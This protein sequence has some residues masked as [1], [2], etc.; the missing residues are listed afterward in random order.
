MK[1]RSKT[2][3]FVITLVFLFLILFVGCN[4]EL[5]EE[6]TT[7]ISTTLIDVTNKETTPPTISISKP[8]AMDVNLGDTIEYIVSF[9]GEN[10]VFINLVESHI[11][12]NGFSAEVSVTGEALTRTIL[13]QNIQ[14]AA[15]GPKYITIPTDIAKDSEGKGNIDKDSPAFKLVDPNV[16]TLPETVNTTHIAM[17]AQDAPKIKT[18][19]KKADTSNVA[20][21]PGTYFD[22]PIAIEDQVFIISVAKYY[23]YEPRLIFQ[24]MSGE[25]SFNR[26]CVTGYC[27]GIMQL[28]KKYWR[29]H[30][31]TKDKFS[32]ILQDGF[33][34]YDIK[35]N[36]LVGIREL[37][38]WRDFA[39]R[40]GY[41]S[42]ESNLECYFNGGAGYL[43]RPNRYTYAE[44]I[45]NQKI[46]TYT[47]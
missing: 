37:S 13:L 19:A 7:D 10:G 14:G 31:N 6:T 24:V 44:Y 40:N 32:Y 46:S 28:H 16:T 39:K 5:Q 33:D 34:V 26:Y 38:Y 29:E 36:V 2:I 43:N 3:V 4:R 11:I 15:G 22:V 20:I 30:V 21:A 41:H 25:S 23:N 18:I 27:H 17:K 42:I 12:L 45:L 1:K 35:Q 8:G 47:V 9:T